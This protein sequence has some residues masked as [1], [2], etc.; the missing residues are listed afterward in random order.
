VDAATVTQEVDVRAV[1]MGS[2]VQLGDNIRVNVQLIDGANNSTLWGESYTRPRSTLYEMEEYLSK[3][4]ADALGI[5]LTGEEGERLTRRYTEN[6]DAHEAYLRGDFE[7][8]KNTAESYRKAIQHFEEAVE[9]DPNYAPAYAAMSVSYYYLGTSVFAMPISEAMSKAEEMATR[10]LEID[11]M[12]G[13]AHAALGAVK[14]RY[15]WDWDGAEEELKRATELDPSNVIAHGTYGQLTSAM[16][17]NDE[18]IASIR[19]GIQLDPSRL[20][21][22]SLLIG[23]FHFARR[24]DDA[25]EQC[26][27]VLDLNPNYQQAYRRLTLVYQ[28]KGLYEEAV[29]S[30]Q[31]WRILQGASEEEV[32]GLAEAYQTSGKEGYWRWLLD[33]EIQNSFNAIF[34]S[35]IYAQLGEKDQ[36]FEQLE[37]AYEERRFQL[38][39]LNVWPPWDPLRDDPRFQDLLRRMNL[40]P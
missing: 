19:R 36:A 4:I 27:I 33:Y 39:N 34:L 13:L 6:S 22:R 7:A 11:D 17:R 1:V 30:Y 16:G 21:L 2:M 35:R 29:P 38:T 18:A 12:L 40:D 37:K 14:F 26:Q 24:Y 31:K 15:H 3:Q 8:R 28:S 32:A 10:A 25:I 9:K 23:A 5:Q 20:G